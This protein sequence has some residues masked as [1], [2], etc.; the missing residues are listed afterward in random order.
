[1][2]AVTSPFLSDDESLAKAPNAKQW[3]DNLVKGL[4]KFGKPVD[5]V[6]GWKEKLNDAGFV[7]L[8][9]EIRK[10]SSF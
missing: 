9:Q 10:V 8:H 4:R 3:M 2:Q 7:D 5:N 1:M 6:G